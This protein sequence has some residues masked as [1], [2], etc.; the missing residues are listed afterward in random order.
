MFDKLKSYQTCEIHSNRTALT[1]YS[2]EEYP[3]PPKD[4]WK[5][6]ADDGVLALKQPNGAIKIW[7]S[8][9]VVEEFKEDGTLRLWYP[10][11]TLKEAVYQDPGSEFFQFF[12]DGSVEAF[13]HG[14]TYL[15]GKSKADRF[16]EGEVLPKKT[17]VDGSTYFDVF[18]K[19]V[20]VDF[21]FGNYDM[22]Y[23]DDGEEI[24]ISE[25]D[26]EHE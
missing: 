4:L 8:T 10:K 14:K 17:G 26:D 25:S 13:T 12:P 2:L 21:K 5:K 7:W 20:W 19:F 11:P 22:D 1:F 6:V 15:W 23:P 16:E 3:L 9:G 18:G 24:H